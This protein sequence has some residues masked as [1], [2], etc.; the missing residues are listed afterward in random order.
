MNAVVR[1]LFNRL[2]ISTLHDAAVVVTLLA[3]TLPFATA[4]RA[5]VSGVLT[6]NGSKVELPYVYV[7][8]EDKGFYD[9]ADPTWRILF[10]ERKLEQRELGEPVW[11]A[12][13]V[14][15]GVTRTSEFDDRPELHIYLQ[16]IKLS[17]K[18]GG[19]I[20]GGTYPKFE[21]N[22][23]GTESISGRVYHTETQEFFD[24]TYSYDFTFSTSLSDP[25]APIG[26]LLPEDGGEPGRAYLNWVA[27]VHSGE[28]DALRKIVPAEM[29]EQLDA[30]S[31]AEA[32]EQIEF[33]QEM[34]PTDVRIVGGSTDGEIAILKIEGTIAGETVPGE[35]TMTRMGEFW[36]PTESSM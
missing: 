6:A 17:A 10:V 3:M 5:D 27:A 9:P 30:I 25:D 8:A 15:I 32:R 35:I 24:K 4:A 31:A 12:A 36:V 22:G 29:A 19:N 18:S 26:D 16:S 21:F 13:W 33:M 28:L 20:S 11:D 7:W 23:L 14:E 1:L 34:T 2:R